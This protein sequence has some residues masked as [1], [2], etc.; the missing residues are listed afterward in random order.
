MSGDVHVRFYERLGVQLPRATHLVILVDGYRRHDWRV[1][2]VNKR[3]REELA[4]L[5]VE[6]NEEKTRLVDLTRTSASDFWGLI[7]AVSRVSTGHGG[8]SLRRS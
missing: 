7:F 1:R 2:A 6:V 5:E 4:K 8:R 3:L